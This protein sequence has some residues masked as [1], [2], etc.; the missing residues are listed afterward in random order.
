VVDER[1]GASPD[2]CVVHSDKGVRVLN[3]GSGDALVDLVEHADVIDVN[4]CS[5]A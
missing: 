1:E 2:P 5:R 4:R 3:V